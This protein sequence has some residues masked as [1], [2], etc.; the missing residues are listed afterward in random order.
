[1]EIKHQDEQFIEWKGRQ[2]QFI[3]AYTITIDKNQGLTLEKW[4]YGWRSLHSPTSR[5]QG[6]ETFNNNL[7]NNNRQKSGSYTRK[8]GVWL[9]KPTFTHVSSS[10]GG[11]LQHLHLVV[12]I[13]LA[14]RPGMLFKKNSHKEVR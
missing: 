10:R 5:P 9:E 6:E 14:E 7:Y 12:K 4:E 3:P 11:D 1:M 2:F 13:A 8:M